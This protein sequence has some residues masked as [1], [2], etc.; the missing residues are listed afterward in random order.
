MHSLV[1][2]TWDFF[3]V[4][5]RIHIHTLQGLPA[6]ETQPL[7]CPVL[8][9]AY[10]KCGEHLPT[11]WHV[12]LDLSLDW[13]WTCLFLFCEIFSLRD[14][15]FFYFLLFPVIEKKKLSGKFLLFLPLSNCSVKWC[16]Q[17]RALTGPWFR[18]G[19]CRCA[20]FPGSGDLLF[21]FWSFLSFLLRVARASLK[22]L[23]FRQCLSCD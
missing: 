13:H 8:L 21:V 1:L 20:F 3:Q 6:W 9:G 2:D 19:C 12:E 14:V 17:P 5:I 23:E 22:S 4:L 10:W 16:H 11:C 18:H 7:C 15:F